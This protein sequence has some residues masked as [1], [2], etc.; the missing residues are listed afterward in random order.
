[1]SR[2][3]FRPDRFPHVLPATLLTLSLSILTAKPSAAQDLYNPAPLPNNG[4]V[5]DVLSDK[6]IPTG[7]GGFA[8]DYVASLEAGDHIVIDLVSEEFDT[9]VTLIAPDGSTFGENDDGPDGTTN[10]LLFARIIQ[11]GDYIV[12]V[13]PYGGQGL[14]TFNLKLTRLRPIN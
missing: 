10:S 7:F 8:R 4:E 3:S 2:F 13:R 11:G 5:T 9:I 12:R 14:G 6:D 1:M